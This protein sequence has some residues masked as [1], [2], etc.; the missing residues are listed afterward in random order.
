MF[1][2]P[3]QKPSEGHMPPIGKA[4]WKQV[5]HTKGLQQPQPTGESWELFR[6]LTGLPGAEQGAPQVPRQLGDTFKAMM[7]F[8]PY[9][10]SYAYI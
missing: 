7:R 4:E 10:V 2:E 3:P 8:S 1:Q 9:A 5:S 6:G